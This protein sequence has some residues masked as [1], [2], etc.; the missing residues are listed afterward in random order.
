MITDINQ[1][2]SPVVGRKAV[3]RWWAD[4]ANRD[5]HFEKCFLRIA[6]STN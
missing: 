2:P 3:V 1:S 4:A 5:A 6:S